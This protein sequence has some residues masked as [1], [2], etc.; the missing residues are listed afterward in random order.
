VIIVKI[1]NR[2]D[3]YIC[4]NIDGYM[5]ELKQNPIMCEVIGEYGQQVK[6][7]FDV[8]A[9]NEDINIDEIKAKINVMFPKKVVNVGNR[10]PREYN[11]KGIKYS[12]RFYVDGVRMTTKNLK[13]Y[14]IDSGFGENNKPFDISIYDINKVL[15]L[16]LTTEKY[17]KNKPN[18]KAPALTPIG[19]DIF[20][21]CASYIKEEFE[22]FDLKFEVKAE[23]PKVIKKVVNNNVDDVDENDDK[24]NQLHEI[25]TKL[26]KNRA[27]DRDSWLN[28][29]YAII[30]I[31]NRNKIRQSKTY[32]L[33]HL[34][35]SLD[36]YDENGVES[37]L[38]INLKMQENKAMDGLSF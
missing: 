16:P 5:T 3:R 9:Y 37:W 21:C 7:C 32:E 14:I 34:F 30:N 1:N 31:C 27:T 22:D 24:I 18:I 28:G 36:N 33:V 15:Y 4:D 19:C 6:P 11:D 38:D 2:N 25:I 26:S 17:V 8:D 23:V 13:Q 20:D 12:Y 29:M 10:E 35:S